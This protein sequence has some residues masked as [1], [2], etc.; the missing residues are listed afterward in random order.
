MNNKSWRFYIDQDK[1]LYKDIY[2]HF[3]D[4]LTSYALRYCQTT[5][6]PIHTYTQHGARMKI[7]S[8]TNFNFPIENN[9]FDHAH[10]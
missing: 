5:V 7:E 10:A 8:L 2:H 3:A 9:I 4:L 1:A 6:R